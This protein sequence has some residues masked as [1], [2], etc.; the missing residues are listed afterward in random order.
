M[1]SALIKQRRGDNMSK[2]DRIQNILVDE[3]EEIYLLKGFKQALLGIYRCGGE[4]S[5]PV[6]SYL[7]LV[8]SLVKDGV[9]EEDAVSYVDSNILSPS[10]SIEDGNLQHTYIIVDDTG[11]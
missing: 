1:G 5:V 7:R 6:Y 10:Q 2:V 8:E 11:V 4:V 3:N 9:S